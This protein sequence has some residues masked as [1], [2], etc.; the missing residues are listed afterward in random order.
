MCL[1]LGT[2]VNRTLLGGDRKAEGGRGS[3]FLYLAAGT[4]PAPCPRPSSASPL[5]RVPG[6]KT[7]SERG[8]R[9]PRSRFFDLGRCRWSLVLGARC[10]CLRCPGQGRRAITSVPLS[11]WRRRPGGPVRPSRCRPPAMVT[12]VAGRGG[13]PGCR[14][15][16]AA[17]RADGSQVR[18]G[19]SVHGHCGHG[20]VGFGVAGWPPV[21]ADR[22]VQWQV[23]AAEV[24]HGVVCR[25]RS[26]GG[27][28]RTAG[29]SAGHVGGGG[30][31]PGETRQAVQRSRLTPCGTACARSRKGFAKS[32]ACGP[33]P[34]RMLRER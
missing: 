4:R 17:G 18:R 25:C 13:W 10:P 5:S 29:W 3:T 1:D 19:L 28:R 27:Q 14:R 34:N 9:G 30:A 8:Q 16:A 33:V 11:P 6:E 15:C 7:A 22:R 24:S 31:D 21:L 20:R 26:G 12:A 23:A 2:G 32:S